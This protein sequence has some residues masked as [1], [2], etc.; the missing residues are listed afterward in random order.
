MSES[1]TLKLRPKR[2]GQPMTQSEIISFLWNV[3]PSLGSYG[4]I[5]PFKWVATLITDIATK[6]TFKT[7]KTSPEPS[8][9]WNYISE[10]TLQILK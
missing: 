2:S 3:I 10:K 4:S 9:D 8:V 7:V 1:N 6:T 5:F